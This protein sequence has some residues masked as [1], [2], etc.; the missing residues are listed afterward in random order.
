SKELSEEKLL[1]KEKPKEDKE[2]AKLE[3]AEEVL[4]IIEED[5]GKKEQ[6]SQ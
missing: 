6:E 3:A 5:K 4:E 2:K 1:S